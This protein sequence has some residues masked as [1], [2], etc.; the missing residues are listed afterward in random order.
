MKQLHS[1]KVNKEMKGKELLVVVNCVFNLLAMIPWRPRLALINA[2]PMNVRAFVQLG[3]P[4]V[5]AML[6]CWLFQIVS[7][8]AIVNSAWMSVPPAT[9]MRF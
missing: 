8:A 7:A 3:S 4:R 9:Q 1:D 6:D 5:S 2:N